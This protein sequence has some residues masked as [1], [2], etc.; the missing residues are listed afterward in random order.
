MCHLGLSIGT[1]G[2]YRSIG[3]VL[4]RPCMSPVVLVCIATPFM[5]MRI[6]SVLVQILRLSSS[7]VGLLGKLSDFMVFQ[8]VMTYCRISSR[9]CPVFIIIIII[10]IMNHFK[11]Q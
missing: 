9:T 2:G 7:F 1:F 5:S 8:H 10:I 11:V 4:T 3:R 6:F